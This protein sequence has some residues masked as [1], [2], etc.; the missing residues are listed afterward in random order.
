MV[1]LRGFGGS[2]GCL[3]WYGPGEKADVNAVKWAASR[4]WSNGR[5]GMYRKSYD[6]LTGLIG[7]DL[8][9]SGLAA[10]VSQE[11]VYDDYRYLYGDGMRRLNSVA[12]PAL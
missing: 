10:V 8:R 7:V 3:D 11:P 1:D 5:V 4:P 9:P 6:G 12:T 2:N